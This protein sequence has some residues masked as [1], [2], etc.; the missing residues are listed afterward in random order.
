MWLKLV[1]SVLVIL[2]SSSIGFQMATRCSGRPRHIR[3]IITCLIS[4]KSYMTYAS[5]PLHEALLQCTHGIH[6][7]VAGFFHTV[8]RM[9]NE[10]GMLSPREAIHMVLTERQGELLLKEPELE[11]LEVG[12]NLGMMD[13]QEQ[14]HYLAMVIEQLETFELE[15]TRFRDLNTK[16]YRYLGVCGGLAVV[17]LLV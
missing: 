5:L 1:G 16:M 9:M 12:G 15:A 8:A 10:Q 6:G 3:Q 2:V 14:G 11:V 13:R 4:L 7:P 17:I